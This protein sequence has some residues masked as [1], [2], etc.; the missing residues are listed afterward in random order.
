ML[1]GIIIDRIRQE[2]PISFHDFM[3][4]AL[5]YPGMGYY[6]SP[7]NKI[8]VN[9]DFLTSSSYTPV[10]GQLLAVQLEEMDRQVNAERFTIVEFGAGTGLLCR[11]ILIQLQGYPHLRDRVR[12]CI[13]EKSL[14]MQERQRKLLGD[15]VTWFSTIEDIGPFE[16]CVLSNELVDN[17]AVHQVVMHEKLM[18]IYVGYDNG[19]T[20]VLYPA[21]ASLIDY[22]AELNVQLPQGF[23]TEINLEAIKWTID[24][25]AILHK[26]F[27]MTIDYGFTSPR[28][29]SASRCNGTLACYYNHA[30][31]Y[32]PYIHIGCQDITSHVNF[33]ALH[34]WGLKNG[35]Q[36]NGF[37]SQ[38]NF[39]MALGFG[40]QVA[41]DGSGYANTHFL[42]HFLLGMGRKFNVLVQQK[43]IELKRLRGMQFPDIF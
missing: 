16:G 21:P 40:R 19:F 29:Y 2:G 15:I 33:S 31:N 8:G 43:N 39:L 32:S 30:V 4:M 37:T 34:H 1:E 12:Y 3:E 42:K 7:G 41:A 10:F 13:I 5:Y 17:F 28:L 26:G 38:A 35:L 11:D 20:E 9:G 27:I 18:E 6:T 14:C 22:L 25:A 24:I 36:L 23:R